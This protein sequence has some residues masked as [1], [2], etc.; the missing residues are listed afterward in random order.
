MSGAAHSTGVRRASRSAAE[1]RTQQLEK[2]FLIKLQLLLIKLLELKPMA[3]AL[4][5]Y[6]T[7]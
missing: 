1:P 6:R 7:N 3:P 5:N 4:V 2:S